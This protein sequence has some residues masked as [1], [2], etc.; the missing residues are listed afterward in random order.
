[1]PLV[2]AGCRKDALEFQAGYHIRGMAIVIG[3]IK[4]WIIWLKTWRQNNRT[5][6][7]IQPPIGHG[8]IDGLCLACLNTLE[9]F[10]AHT[11]VKTARSLSLCGLLIHGEVGL[12]KGVYSF[13]NGKGGDRCAGFLRFMWINGGIVLFFTVRLGE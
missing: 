5:H 8:M 7:N 9:T 12:F 10:T 4:R 11:T 6:S 3:V 2:R 1:V 13:S